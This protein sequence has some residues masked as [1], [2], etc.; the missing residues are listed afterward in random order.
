MHQRSRTI[1][2]LS[3]SQPQSENPTRSTTQ[4]SSHISSQANPSGSPT[5]LMLTISSESI[6]HTSTYYPRCHS[7]SSRSSTSTTSD[8]HIASASGNPSIHCIARGALTF[9]ITTSPHHIHRLDG[10]PFV[11]HNGRRILAGLAPLQ[12]SAGFE[13]RGAKRDQLVRRRGYEGRE[14]ARVHDIEFV[15][16]VCG[17]A[18]RV[19]GVALEELWQFGGS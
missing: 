5:P 1:L 12:V 2:H 19:E 9:F 15:A 14:I 11:G 17:W 10:R 13:Q 7:R 3:S 8:P 18:C 6:D 16:Q 4:P